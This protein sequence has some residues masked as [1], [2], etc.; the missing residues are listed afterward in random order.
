MAG[1][2]IALMLCGDAGCELRPVEP[3]VSYPTFETCSSALTEK[4]EKLHELLRQTATSGQ[5]TNI[6]CVNLTR[7]VTEVEEPYEVLD[8]AIV[9]AEPSATAAYVGIVEQ[10]GRTLVTGLVTGTAWVRVLLSD[11]KTGFVYGD[12][13]RKI[14]GG[15]ATAQPAAPNTTSAHVSGSQSALSEQG[16]SSPTPIPSS[17][18][19]DCDTCPVM[20]GLQAG[21]FVM[22]SGSDPTERPRHLVHIK[23]F[24]IAKFELTWSE[25]QAC[26]VEGGCGYSPPPPGSDPEREPIGNLSWDDA[27]EYVNWLAKRTSKP[28]RLPTE[29]E[30]EF[31]ARA[32]TNFRYSWGDQVGV[33]RASCAGCGGSRDPL[34]P[35]PTGSYPANNWGIFDVEGGL[36][37]WVE[38]CWHPSYQGAPNDGSA[39]RTSGCMTH[40]LRGGSWN[41][42]PND[43]TVTSRNFYDSNVRYLANGLRVS[44]SLP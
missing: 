7:A 5:T 44:M 35:P 24:A 19:R 22:G 8:S 14:G 31:A 38:D 1:F 20:I 23:R 34:H 18:H 17:E 16:Q 43:I 29:A 39:W 2:M 28:Y 11:G 4:S 32:G 26:V 25:W 3:E 21:E 42:G 9:H 30:W 27:S 12:R 6:V 37:E 33:G 41:N 13:L 10:G 15:S 40:V 36:A